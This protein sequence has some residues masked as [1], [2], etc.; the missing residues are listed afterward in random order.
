MKMKKEPIT[1]AAPS[2]EKNIFTPKNTVIVGSNPT[3]GM[4]VGLYLFCFRVR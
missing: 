2:K 1:L 3:Q 4:V